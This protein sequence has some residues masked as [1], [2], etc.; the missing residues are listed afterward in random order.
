METIPGLNKNTGVKKYHSIILSI[1]I[2]LKQKAKNYSAFLS[3]NCYS[4]INKLLLGMVP[5]TNE[6]GYQK[7]V[8]KS[9]ESIQGRALKVVTRAYKATSLSALDIKSFVLPIRQRLDKLSSESLLR[10]AS[11]QHY[12]TIVLQRPRASKIK[13]ISLLEILSRRFEKHFKCKI[14]HI[15]RTLPFITLLWWI[16]PTIDIAPF[17]HQAKARYDTILQAHDLQKQLIAYINGSG[18]NSKIGAATI[19]IS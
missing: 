5:P 4:T 9:L 17:K 10:I 11:S 16:P 7:Y 2:Y 3:I 19:V 12:K 18:I 13:D 15:K 14:E 6:P 8:S 1:W